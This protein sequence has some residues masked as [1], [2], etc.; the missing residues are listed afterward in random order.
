MARRKEYD[1]IVVGGGPGGVTCAAF[2][3][4]WGLKTLLIEKNER[5]G[6]KMITLSKKIGRAHV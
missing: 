4:K 1:V 6:G 2:L 5:V 3:A